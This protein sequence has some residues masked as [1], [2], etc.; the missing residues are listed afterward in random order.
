MA[1]DRKQHRQASPSAPARPYPNKRTRSDDP[2]TLMS[3]PDPASPSSSSDQILAAFASF[4]DEID[5]HNDRRERLIKISR[6]V[7]SL[8][9]KVIFLLHRFDIHDFGSADPSGKTRKLFSDA[10]TKLEEIVS[11]LRK[12]A[13]T[14]GFVA[15][16]AEAEEEEEAVMDASTSKLRS[17]RYE[18]NIGGGLEEFIEAISFYHYLR[19]TQLITLAQIQARFLSSPVTESSFYSSS[20]SPTNTTGP[21]TSHSEGK[22]QVVL[23]IPTHRYLLGLSDLTGEL[24]RFATNAVGQGGTGTLVQQV[25]SITRQLRDGLDTFIPLVRDMKKK[26]VVTNQSLRKI[27]DILYAITVRSAEYG[28]DPKALQ[29][30]VRRAL[31]STCSGQNSRDNDEDD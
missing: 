16:Q 27:E 2:R 18:R 7:T 28:S 31:A 1:E 10:G 12:A 26:Q 3:S 17:Q 13:Q 6:D 14:E 19:T 11:L 20:T 25:L 15:I 24:M 4:R 30:M 8:S 21:S 22:H 5:A 9:K 23:P 29:E